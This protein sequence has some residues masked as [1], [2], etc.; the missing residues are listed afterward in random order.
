VAQSSS[1]GV[2]RGPGPDATDATAQVAAFVDGIV[3][4]HGH[5]SGGRSSVAADE[6]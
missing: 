3:S 4:E 5:V 1:V 2:E 6:V